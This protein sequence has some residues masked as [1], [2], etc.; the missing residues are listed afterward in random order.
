M[1]ARSAPH[2]D[3]TPRLAADHITIGG[4]A[5]AVRQ[6]VVQAT[7]F[8]TL[9]HFEHDGLPA[10]PRILVVEPLS[11]IRAPM[12][13]DMLTDLLA[14]C[15][16]YVLIWTDPASVEV[17]AGTF[18]LG[19]NIDAVVYA[20]QY[21][22]PG[23]HLIGLCQ[24]AMPAL[25][26]TA[27]LCAGAPASRPATLTLLGSKLDTRINPTRLDA[28]TRN[29]TLG[30]FARNTITLVPPFRLG[31]GRAV[32]S[33]GL[34]SVLLLTYIARHTL[35]G[36][37]IFRK[38]VH[39]DGDDTAAHPFLGLLFSPVAIPAEFFL[40]AVFTTFHDSTLAEGR[41]RWRGLKVNLGAITDVPLLTIE[42][43]EDDI[44]APGQTYIAHRLCAALPPALRA[45]HLE[46]GIGHF[47]L[48]HGAVWR[49]SLLPRLLGFLRGHRQS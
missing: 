48:F 39:D 19:D 31:A 15:D 46:P 16:V 23:T 5:H 6:R 20:L 27:I 38:I 4:H 28:L 10:S 43:G 42:A 37:E 35:T 26:A 18:G 24:S 47:G 13:F 3:F 34:Q 25:A 29:F 49:Q 1:T 32:Y 9:L 44:A 12:L 2:P 21:L 8:F 22:G 33:A 41:L 40:D 36:G 17:T 11:G 30:W 14:S 45:H 7:P